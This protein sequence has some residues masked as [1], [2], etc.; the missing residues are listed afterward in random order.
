MSD[1]IISP[2][3]GA[4]KLKTGK[5]TRHSAENTLNEQT[6]E[7]MAPLIYYFHMIKMINA[8][9]CSDADM[10]FFG[11]QITMNRKRNIAYSRS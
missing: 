9:T 3:E 1:L 11:Y 4:L 6:N 10:E 2:N 8:F 5:I 7:D